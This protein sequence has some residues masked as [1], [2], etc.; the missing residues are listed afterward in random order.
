M[1]N[2]YCEKNIEHNSNGTKD[3]IFIW[4]CFN[5]CYKD[6][7]QAEKI[8]CNVVFQIDAFSRNP[9]YG[10]DVSTLSQ[11]PSEGEVII[12][13]G[14]TFFIEEIKKQENKKVLI[15]LK[16]INDDDD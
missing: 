12:N 15:V 13:A 14:S 1:L 9:R 5:S 10:I 4:Q 11:Y 7:E 8:D 16:Q 2:S 3:E 6:K